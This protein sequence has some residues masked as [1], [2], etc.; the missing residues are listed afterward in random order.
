MFTIITH[1]FKLLTWDLARD[2]LYW[3]VWWYKEGLSMAWHFFLKQLFSWHKRLGV[4]IW[5][6][7]WF[8]PM[9]AQYDWQ[10]RLISFFFRTVTIIWK[11]FL[12]LLGL[13]VF[14][15]VFLLYIILPFMAVI[16]LVISFIWV[17]K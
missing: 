3:P 16:F 12:F 1:T 8:K 17:A 11:S 5:I 15:A 10:G 14:S 6:K 7:N 13:L 4:G 9:Y 2:I